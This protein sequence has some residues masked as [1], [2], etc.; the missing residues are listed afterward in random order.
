MA[1]TVK[2]DPRFRGRP[3]L[4]DLRDRTRQSFREATAMMVSRVRLFRVQRGTPDKAP[5]LSLGWM[6]MT[7]RLAPRFP[8]LRVPKARPVRMRRSF[9]DPAV[10][11]EMKARLFPV[12]RERPVLL[13]SRFLGWMAMMVRQGRRLPVRKVP[14]E[15]Q[16][17][18][19]PSFPATMEM[20]GP[21]A[22]SSQVRREIQARP[23]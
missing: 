17:R 12:H 15:L 10:T 3:A 7:E 13:A 14:K 23:D 20:M 22:P 9:P 19:H 5:R 21:K 16:G 1:M 6:G 2:L 11:M 8:D 4:R 18:M